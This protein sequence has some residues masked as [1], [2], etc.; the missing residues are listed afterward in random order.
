MRAA[1]ELEE[2]LLDADGREEH[3]DGREELE[4]RLLDALETEE[5]W[6]SVTSAA[7]RAL[8]AARSALEVGGEGLGGAVAPQQRGG[9]DL[10]VLLQVRVEA[11][12]GEEDS[13]EEGVGERSGHGAKL[14]GGGG[15]ERG[16][17]AQREGLGVGAAEAVEGGG[18]V[19]VGDDHRQE[20]SRPSVG[21]KR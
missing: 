12:V 21:G 1:S 15:G 9:R 4:E 19:G 17:E 14:D 3:V 5:C 6:N 20:A 13:E 10:V 2:R 11:A 7:A 16:G 8:A 18:A